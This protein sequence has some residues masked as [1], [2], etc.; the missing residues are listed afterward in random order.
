MF[1]RWITPY[2]WRMFRWCF[3]H[4]V[5]C[6]QKFRFFAS[7]ART[8][9]A[10]LSTSF[11]FLFLYSLFFSLV[12]SFLVSFSFFF[13]FLR[14]SLSRTKTASIDMRTLQNKKVLQ[15]DE[16]LLSLYYKW[17]HFCKMLLCFNLQCVLFNFHNLVHWKHH[18]FHYLQCVVCKIYKN[19]NFLHTACIVCNFIFA[20]LEIHV[21]FCCDD[22]NF[23]TRRSLCAV[24]FLHIYNVVCNFSKSMIFC[25]I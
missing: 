7:R 15:N 10:F 11:S 14:L 4:F 18:F 17:W 23:C 16:F 2:G 24:L 25:I 12:L 19:T 8:R 1:T 5:A 3:A 22:C 13:L 21:Q 9:L 6:V 20:H